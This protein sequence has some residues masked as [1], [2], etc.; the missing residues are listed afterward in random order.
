[1]AEQPRLPLM[2]PLGLGLP[3][4]GPLLDISLPTRDLTKQENEIG[5]QQVWEIP[6]NLFS[7][8]VLSSSPWYWNMGFAMRCSRCQTPA[9]PLGRCEALAGH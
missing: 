8:R 7:T 9:L 1:M 6:L 5:K 2:D 4:C 3:L